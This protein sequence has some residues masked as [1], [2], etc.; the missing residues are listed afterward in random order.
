MK[1]SSVRTILQALNASGVRFLIAGGLAVNAHGF[2]RFTKDLDLVVDLTPTNIRALFS[3]L[4]GIGYHPA[5]PISAEQFADSDLRS[6]LI[7]EKGMQ[8]LQFWSDAHRETAVDVFVS[9]PFPFGEEYERAVVKEFTGTNPVRIV[10]LPT[11]IRM[12]E[13]AGRPEDRIDSENLRRRLE[14]S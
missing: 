13:E 8:V 2:H 14:G 9:E 7:E 4:D 11:L 6:R 12:K 3:A 10:A 5:V 1:L